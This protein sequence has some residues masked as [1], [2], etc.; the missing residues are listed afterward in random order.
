MAVNKK[1]VGIELN[2]LLKKLNDEE[3]AYLLEIIATSFD[4]TI[5]VKKIDK[6]DDRIAGWVVFLAGIAGECLLKMTAATAGWV[7]GGGAISDMPIDEVC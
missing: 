1:K 7:S 3:R 2:D 5:K 6:P 4:N